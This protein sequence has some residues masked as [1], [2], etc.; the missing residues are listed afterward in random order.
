MGGANMNII[1]TYFQA[2]IPKLKIFLEIK[3]NK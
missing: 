1:K 2:I 3:G